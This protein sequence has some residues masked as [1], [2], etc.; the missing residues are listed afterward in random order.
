MWLPTKQLLHCVAHWRVIPEPSFQEGFTFKR[1]S[2]SWKEKW[3]RAEQEHKGAFGS[4]Q[5]ARESLRSRSSWWRRMARGPEGKSQTLAEQGLWQGWEEVAFTALCL[6]DVFSNICYWPSYFELLITIVITSS[7]QLI[8][9]LQYQYLHLHSLF[10]PL[11][12]LQQSG[13]NVTLLHM[14]PV[15]MLLKKPDFLM[16]F[17]F[18]WLFLQTE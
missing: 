9:T 8:L 4:S 18:V 14:V 1:L 15:N 5:G 10:L 16:S 3:N 7:F 13:N 11:K 17:A 12:Y 6:W 2:G